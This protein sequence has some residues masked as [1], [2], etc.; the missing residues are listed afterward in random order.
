MTMRLQGQ[1]VLITGSAQGIGKATALVYAR[2]GASIASIDINGAG[3]EQ[4]AREAAEMGAPVTLALTCDVTD[5]AQVEATIKNAAEVLGGLDILVNTAAWLDPPIP[6][7]E[8]PFEVWNKSITTDLNSVFLCCKHALQVMIPQNQGGRIIN[9]SSGAGRRGR[10]MR[11][12][13]GAAKAAII[14]LTESLALE[15]GQY[16]IT[17]NA[18]CPGGVIGDRSLN[19]HRQ[20]A[21]RQGRSREEGEKEY[22]QMKARYV[23]ED[24]VAE[25]CLFL[26][27]P[28]AD[29]INGQ[30]IG[31]G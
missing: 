1:R 3:A 4:T 5:E 6:V 8:M 27:T 30:A 20:M 25:L 14:N 11:S 17:V 16:G 23:T 15:N 28:E 18:I 26:A 19:I 13:Y 22:E 24:K 10:A 12:S 21:E 9:L 31:I 7:A 2:E 29:R